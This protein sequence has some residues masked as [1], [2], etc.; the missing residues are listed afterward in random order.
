MK[1]INFRHIESDLR[2]YLSTGRVDADGA[3]QLLFS[4]AAFHG[5]SEALRYLS[6]IWTQVV[7]A[8]HSLL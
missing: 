6:C 4:G 2:S 7:E 8:D 1:K 5:C 3:V